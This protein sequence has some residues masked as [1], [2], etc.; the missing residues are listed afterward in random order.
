MTYING[1][2]KEKAICRISELFYY[3]KPRMTVN[4]CRGKTTANC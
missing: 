2:D 4:M 3:W 1:Y